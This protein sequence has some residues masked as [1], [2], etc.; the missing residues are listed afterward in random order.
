MK[1]SYQL[2]RNPS[3]Y[4][5]AVIDHLETALTLEIPSSYKR[6]A[7]SPETVEITYRCGQSKIMKEDTNDGREKH[8]IE[9]IFSITVNTSNEGFDLEALDAS[10]RIEREF[11]NSYF[12]LG[13]SVELPDYIVN[14]PQIIDDEHG[15]LIRAVTVRQSVSIGEVD[16]EYFE[17]MSGGVYVS[18][19]N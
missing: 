16:E 4:V 1:R 11:Q 18:G 14:E 10:S 12:G 2:L 3:D 17:M 5:K 6:I 9:L 15:Y 19:N 8:S 13:D 7:S